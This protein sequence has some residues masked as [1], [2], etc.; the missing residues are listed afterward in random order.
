MTS[1]HPAAPT[2]RQQVFRGG[3]FL[4][5]RH[6]IGTVVS[7][8]G[9]L[10]VTHLIGPSQYGLFVA[11]LGVFAFFNF[12]AQW[13]VNIYLIR[14]EGP[15]DDR[16]YDVA[17]TLLLSLGF[18]AASL[19]MLS[20]GL[21]QR[22]AGHPGFAPLAIG[23]FAG[24]PLGVLTIIPSAR[25][26][27]AMD[28]SR[29][30]AVEVTNVLVLHATSV[31]AALAGFAAWS[32]V[33]G[34]WVQQVV[35]AA[36]LFWLAGYRPRLMWDPARV[37]SMLS[38][39]LG[40][41]TS[42]WVFQLRSLLNT[43][44]VLPLAGPAAVGCVGLA[45]KFVEALSLL[46][47]MTWRLSIPALTRLNGDP[48]R[49]LRA[50]TDGMRLQVLGV[51]GMLASFAIVAPYLLPRLFGAQWP[52][53]AGSMDIFPYIALSMLVNTFF[54]LHSSVLY[55]LGRNWLVTIFHAVHVALLFAAAWYFVPRYGLLGVG[56]AEIVAFGSYLLMH[57]FVKRVVGSPEYRI[58]AVWCAAL[59]LLLFSRQLGWMAYAGVLAAALWPPTWHAI[60]EYVRLI[61]PMA[62]PS[63]G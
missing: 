55:V 5:A 59:S 9:T 34:W 62:A 60:Q 36:L 58:A 39:G 24:L 45:S 25:I 29:L 40:Y 4:A 1:D 26:E 35:G 15:T 3:A 53:W 30:A 63:H 20:M 6:A 10:L 50:L 27:R 47:N 54:G 17:F 31:M 8:A 46:K 48:V 38:F 57:I 18:A 37:K 11:A 22:W 33:T 28:Y 14:R 49:M 42:L 44:V 7:T 52:E 32:P 21:V 61:R 41:C 23:L 16:D 51:G 12:V 56:Y 43:V 2:F 19:G 13:G